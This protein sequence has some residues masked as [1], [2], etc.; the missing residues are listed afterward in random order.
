ML[1]TLFCDA[2]F[3]HKTAAG[4][5]GAWAKREDWPRGK[6]ACGRVFGAHNSTEAE[7]LGIAEAITV[8]LALGWLDQAD[9][10]I[11]C[12]NLAALAVIYYSAD[13]IDTPTK[14]GIRIA[15]HGKPDIS[16][17]MRRALQSTTEALGGK[18]VFLRHV[19][20]HSDASCGRSWVNKQCDLLAKREM[21]K[22]RREIVGGQET[23]SRYRVR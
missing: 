16:P 5:W 17:V 9:V 13:G 2:S 3:D 12:D 8:S 1:L 11:Q 21:N 4:G 15:D 14:N 10:M 19:K 23:I 7:L 18:R 6:D 22:F 20:G